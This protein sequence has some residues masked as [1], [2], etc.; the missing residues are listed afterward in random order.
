MIKSNYKLIAVLLTAVFTAGALQPPVTEAGLNIFDKAKEAIG[1][2]P[3]KKRIK[4]RI[5]PGTPMVLANGQRYQIIDL[6]GGYRKAK[7][8]AER[9]GGHL[10]KIDSPGENKL[11]YDFM[12]AQGYKAAYFGLSDV[13][14]DGEWQYADGSKPKYKN[15]HKEHPVKDDP[16]MVYAMLYSLYTNGKWKSGTFSNMVKVKGGTAFII[17]WDT[18]FKKKEVVKPVYDEEKDWAAPTYSDEAEN[19]APSS[20]VEEIDVIS[21]ETVYETDENQAE[22]V[23]EE[24]VISG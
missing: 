21:D 19:W 4:R 18:I 2:G 16:H 20:S 10:A 22:V 6:G 12:I 24:D 15:W 7:A 13:N 1:L 8:Y 11:L 17:E 14:L 3:S 5:K 23:E 9:Q